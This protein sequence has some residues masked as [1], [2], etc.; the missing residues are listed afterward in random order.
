MA[1]IVERLDKIREHY[2]YIVTT[3]GENY[4][5]DISIQ[6]EC[7]LLMRS[8]TKKT[9]YAVYK[10]RINSLFAEGYDEFGALSIGGRSTKRSL[11]VNDD[12]KLQEIAEIY[13]I[14]HEKY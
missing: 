4:D 13:F 9:A 11:P 14:D 1:G 3:Y 6:D 12:P 7:L 5:Y 10:R 2:N 8:P